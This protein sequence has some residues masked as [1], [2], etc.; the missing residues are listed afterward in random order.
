MALAVKH[1]LLVFDPERDDVRLPESGLVLPIAE[2]KT[3][4]RK[5]TIEQLIA[6]T[7]W[8]FNLPTVCKVNGEYFARS[9]WATYRV[10]ANDNVEFV[11]RPLGGMGGQGG[12]SAKSIGAIV[13]MVALTALAPWAMGAIGLTGTAASIGSSLLIAGGAMAISHFLKPKAGGK[14]AETE[15]LY[16]FGFGGNQARPLQP[17]PVGYG[18][19][20]SFPDFAAPKYSEYNGDSMTEYALLCIGCGKYDIEEVRIA[21]TR[22]WT[23]SGGYN[24]S[25]PG[26]SIRI[27]SPGEKVTLFPQSTW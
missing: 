3:R 20:L 16:S 14:T 8:Q 11:S 24:P 22:I 10:A 17:I 12:S 13:A 1:N 18:R 9:E 21:D 5:P 7:G 25:F 4:K 19:T 27:Q 6:E 23:K 2:H 15:E 26:I